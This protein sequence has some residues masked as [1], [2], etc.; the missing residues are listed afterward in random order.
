MQQS[1]H[2]ILLLDDDEDIRELLGIVLTLKGYKV[3]AVTAIDEFSFNIKPDLILLDVLLAGKNG[4]DICASLKNDSGTT[5]IPVIMFSG[6]SDVKQACLNAG[7]DEFILKP[8]KIPALY[9]LI[10]NL[11]AKSAVLSEA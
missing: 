11:L 1:V 3:I 4:L 7:A 2:N 5:N 9:T 10:K 8:F 6:L